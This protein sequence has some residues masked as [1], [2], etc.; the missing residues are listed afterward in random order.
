MKFVA[1]AAIALGSFA[2]GFN[3]ENIQ[4]RAADKLT[5]SAIGTINQC[6][7]VANEYAAALTSCR[8]GAG[9]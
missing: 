9:Q 4:T 8:G 6:L 5:R 1:I 2:L 7:S 3:V